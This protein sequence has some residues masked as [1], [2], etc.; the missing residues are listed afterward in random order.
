MKKNRNLLFGLAAIRSGKVSPDRVAFLAQQSQQEGAADLGGR[1]VA[2]GALSEEDRRAIDEMVDMEL[3]AREGDVTATIAAFSKGHTRSTPP[4]TVSGGT[5][6]LPTFSGSLFSDAGTPTIQG[7]APSAD[8]FANEPAPASVLSMPGMRESEG[9]YEELRTVAKGGMGRILLVRDSVLHR[10]VAMKQLLP[11]L[12]GASAAPGAATADMLTTPLA[13]RFLQEARVTGQLEHPAIVPVYELGTRKDGALYYTMRLVKGRSLEEEIAARGDLADRLRLLP[14]FLDLCQAVAFAHSR[15]IIHRDLK[16]LNVMIGEFGETVV[17]DW[18]IAKV[19]KGHDIHAREFREQVDMYRAGG[20]EATVKTAYGQTLGSP[21]YMPPEQSGGDPDLVDARSDVYAL[22]ATL[23]AILAGRPPYHGITV[24]EFLERVGS[25]DPKPVVSVEPRAPKELAAVCARAMARRPEDRYATAAELAE[26]VDRYLSGGLVSAY[27]Y[28]VSELFRRFVRRHRAILATAGAAAAALLVLGVY[29]YLRVSNERDFALEQQAAAVAER[30]RAEAARD[31]ARQA[32]AASDEQRARAERELYFANIALA[33]RSIQETRMEQARALVDAAP[34]AH[35]DWEWAWLAGETRPEGLLLKAGGVFTAFADQGRQLITA[36]PN[37]TLTGSGTADGGQVRVYLDKAGFG[38]AF[39]VDA[40]GARLAAAVQKSISVWN[41]SDGAEIFHFD[42]PGQAFPRAFLALSADGSR[43]AA[44]NTDKKMRVWALPGGEV[45]Y[46]SIVA[47]HQGFG[48]FL[49]RDGSLM[50]L[51][52]ARM[53]ETGMVRN[54]DLLRLPSGESA[55]HLALDDVQS[56]HGAAFSPDGVLV[57]LALD[58]RVEIWDTGEWKERQK[59]P[60]RAGYSEALAFSPDS[61]TF[62]AA[63][64]DGSLLVWPVGAEKERRIAGA[65]KD[66]IRVVAFSPDGKM[67]ATAGFDRTARLWEMPDAR[68]AGVLRGHD[69][70]LFSVAFSPDGNMAA[71]GSFDGAARLWDLRRE[72]DRVLPGHPV[73]S[74]DGRCLAG[75]VAG[76]VAVWDTSTGRRTVTLDTVDAETEFI[77]MSPDGGRLAAALFTR[78]EPRTHIAVVWNLTDGVR[79]LE[80]PLDERADLLAFTGPGHALLA[81]RQ[82][83]RLAVLDGEG[84]RVWEAASVVDVCFRPD[85]GQ[86]AVCSV[87]GDA[88]AM[89]DRMNIALHETGGWQ[90][91]ADLTVPTSFTAALAYSPDSARLAAGAALLEEKN[92]RGGAYVWTLDNPA[93]PAWLQ[94]HDSLVTAVAFS[95]DG[96]LIATGDKNGRLVLWDTASGGARRRITG[97]AADVHGI[98][99]N[100][101]GTRM[102]T[103]GRDGAFKLWDTADGREILTLASVASVSGQNASPDTV[104]FDPESRFLMTMTAPETQF[105]LLLRALPGEL[106]APAPQDS[107]LEER[108]TSWQKSVWPPK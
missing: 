35:R 26:E 80:T 23:Y 6:E 85:G 62:A 108:I 48:V 59:L 41:T 78:S 90:K 92:W 36:Q 93:T 99:F 51:A 52:T 54:V 44:L 56:L 3:E 32:Q 49:N 30:G 31:E 37:G 81:A 103:A 61:R 1:L 74:A 98:A 63:T 53:G 101:A 15:D 97:H 24:R 89:R 47:T 27:E 42:E 21:Y 14:H 50:L 18:G 106:C 13:A 77:V 71:T 45:L 86:I 79:I 64:T 2:E 39:A 55:G 105:P 76:G 60:G 94:G 72:L 4:K 40:A 96:K 82:G 58:D 22:G 73:L 46:E 102:A 12:P 20:P 38:G 107:P 69:Q 65:H 16:P 87:P 84:N 25:F 19:G 104:A 5:G 11:G 83:S 75:T 88:T 17:I 43:L 29:S 33:Q 7:G 66:G 68:P 70:S 8:T 95:K 91:T 28:H 9:R 57:A 34:A 67:L 100:S 10:E